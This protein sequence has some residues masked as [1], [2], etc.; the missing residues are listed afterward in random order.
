MTKQ[1]PLKATGAHVS[2]VAHITN[3]EL[4]REIRD[5]AEMFNGFANGFLWCYAARS[6]FIPQ[7][8]PLPEGYLNE[9]IHSLREALVLGRKQG[10]MRRD[11]AAEALWAKAYER[12]SSDP[13]GLL[14][15]LGS[16]FIFFQLQVAGVI[17]V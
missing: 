9:E 10:L 3:G 13:R 4:Q 14:G 5:T 1:R 15:E 6:K 11:E 8:V 12:L 2:V 17:F 16:V 7:S